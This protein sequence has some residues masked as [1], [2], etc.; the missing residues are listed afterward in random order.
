VINEDLFRRYFY[1]RTTDL[2]RTFLS[3]QAFLDG[4]YNYKNRS[5]SINFPIYTMDIPRENLTPN[6]FFCPRMSVVSEEF[7]KSQEYHDHVES[8]TNPL[9]ARVAQILNTTINGVEVAGFSDC[10]VSEYC[11]GH[12]LPAGITMD[13]VLE[14]LDEM[15]WLYGGYL[16]YPSREVAT[17]YAFGNF[18]EEYLNR[19][20]KSYRR[21]DEIKFVFYSAHDFSIA[22]FLIAFKVWDNK[23]P[24]FAQMVIT[25][26]YEEG[27]IRTFRILVDGRAYT[28][29][30]CTEY[31]P[32]FFVEK[33]LQEVIPQEGECNVPQQ[34][35]PFLK[36]N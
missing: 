34:S 36:F 11:H 25:E 28:I 12:A 20:N 14:V 9:A 24:H 5:G 32:Y 19:I 7:M 16:I 1:F 33:L 30:G 29:P 17:R 8:I 31:C 6:P 18:L 15:A 3:A 27:N 35:Q 13:I 21:E 22:A 2:H 26:F 23:W 10:W 4:L